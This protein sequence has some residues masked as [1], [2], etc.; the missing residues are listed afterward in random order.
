MRFVFV[1]RFKEFG[2]NN[3]SNTKTFKTTA[4]SPK[5]AAKHL[6]KKGQIIS[7]RKLKKIL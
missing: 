7:V 2:R 1:V 6:K 4:R 5:D 3:H